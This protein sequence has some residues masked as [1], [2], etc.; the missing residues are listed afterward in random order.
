W[1]FSDTMNGLMAIPNLICLLV[2]SGDIAKEC[3]DYQ[4]GFI[5]PEREARKNTKA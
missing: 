2:L 1:N 3:F 5:V 4:E